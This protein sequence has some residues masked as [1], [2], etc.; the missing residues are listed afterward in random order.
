[1][2]APIFH[3]ESESEIGFQ[4]F[5]G[6]SEIRPKTPKFWS[7]WPYLKNPW[8]FLK[9]DF[10][11]GFL[12]K[13]W[14]RRGRR[15]ITT[16]LRLGASFLAKSSFIISTLKWIDL[17]ME[18]RNFNRLQICTRVFKVVPR[19]KFHAESIW[20]EAIGARGSYR[21]LLWQISQ[22]ATS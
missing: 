11:F 12:V 17:L 4:K 14:C 5:S 22:W 6:V 18:P 16:V 8:E 13:N 19:G 20:P 21:T 9:S 7:F 3:E 15:P 1:M 2:S 10:R